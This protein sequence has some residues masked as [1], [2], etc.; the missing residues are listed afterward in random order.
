MES[1]TLQE[2]PL[3]SWSDLPRLE[4]VI[5]VT[6]AAAIQT[7]IHHLPIYTTDKIEILNFQLQ[8]VW[9]RKF[10]GAKMWWLIYSKNLL[11]Y[12]SA[13]LAGGPFT[14]NGLSET[15]LC[16]QP[17]ACWTPNGK[18]SPSNGTNLSRKELSH[19]SLGS[20]G[21]MME[22][23]FFL[24]SVAEMSKLLLTSSS[25]F[26]SVGHSSFDHQKRM[27]IVFFFELY[28]IN[29]LTSHRHCFSK[30]TDNYCNC[31]L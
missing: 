28:D 29:Q 30:A 11:K 3:S 20:Q 19:S 12:F 6:K 16:F 31:L 22:I 17:F 2:D 21:P 23:R 4:G 7:V 25:Q 10:M 27:M 13:S 24:K 15:S 9:P 1:N 26:K 14:E 8:R 18:C 5:K